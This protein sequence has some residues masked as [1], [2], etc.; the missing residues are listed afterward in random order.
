MGEGQLQNFVRAK[1]KNMTV[2]NMSFLLREKR[3][4]L[5]TGIKVLSNHVTDIIYWYEQNFLTDIHDK[6]INN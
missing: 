4:P 5:K 3:R 6:I 1:G 2:K